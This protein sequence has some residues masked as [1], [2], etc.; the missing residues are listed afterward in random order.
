MSNESDKI[1][2]EYWIDGNKNNLEYHSSVNKFSDISYFLP[3]L[4]YYVKDRH[5]YIKDIMTVVELGVRGGESTVALYSA[6]YEINTIL[7]KKAELYSVDIDNVFEGVSNRLKKIDTSLEY[8][9][10]I[11]D[12]DISLAKKW[13]KFIDVLFIDTSHKK[14]HTIQ[15]LSLWM[16][17]LKQN[18]VA[19]FHDTRSTSPTEILN[20]LLDL[21]NLNKNS[22][23]FYEIPLITGLGIIIKK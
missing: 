9:K 15:E 17:F 23:D 21:C 1:Y 14:E 16:P 8:W 11:H 2:Y 4:Y 12:D 22:Y 19:L 7:Q 5:T 10:F 3:I 6:V 18:G 13:S 20:P